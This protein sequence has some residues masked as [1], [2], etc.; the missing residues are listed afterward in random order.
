MFIQVHFL[1]RH[2][3]SLPNR[4]RDGLQKSIP[5]G[6]AERMRVSSQSF[7]QSLRS[8]DSFVRMTKDGNYVN[9]SLKDIALSLGLGSSE[10]SQYIFEKKVKPM[11]LKEGFSEDEA[12][13]WSLALLDIFGKDDKKATSLK[14][15]QP[16][17]LGE[18]EI[19]T[20]VSICVKAKNS[21]IDLK[22]FSTDIKK[23]N[24]GKSEFAEEFQILR[25][26][27]ANAGIDGA[28]F[29]RMS[30]GD[31]FN[32]VQGCVSVSHLIGVTPMLRT[33]DFF[34]VVDT[35]KDAETM[36][37]GSAHI[38]TVDLVTG[39]LYGQVV[40]NLKSFDDNFGKVDLGG[41]NSNDRSKLVSWLVR[42]IGQNQYSAKL[43][44]T[45]DF[46]TLDDFIVEISP[47]QP[48]SLLGAFE[49]SINPEFGESVKN[50][51][52]ER[53]NEEISRQDSIVGAPLMRYRLGIDNPTNLSNIEY[54]SDLVEDWINNN[55]YNNIS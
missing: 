5:F 6:D 25:S 31:L 32:T 13:D 33:A 22:D 43:G 44:S 45:S 19:K 52:I 24:G 20:I 42:A 40:I 30:T 14:S 39:T 34:S 27:P 35:L 3:A 10:R 48:R 53:L 41:L 46:S 23:A 26:L 18:I 49:Q 36:D 12:M 50:I 11:L 51:A 4:G 28:L 8:N 16:L 17:V 2:V 47:R 21:G 38:N 1:R 15:S 37:A 55:Y 9:D 7:K 54:I 29:G